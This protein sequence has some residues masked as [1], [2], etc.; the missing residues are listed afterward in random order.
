MTSAKPPKQSNESHDADKSRGEW[1]LTQE[2]FDKLLA[3]FSHDTDEAAKQYEA[4]RV[5]LIRFF[6]WRSGPLADKYADEVFNRV[7]RRIGEGQ[8]VN[9][10]VRYAYRVAYLVFL[11][12]LKEPDLVDIDQELI[13]PHTIE[14]QYEDTEHEQRQRCFDSCLDGL[15]ISNRKLILG[16]YQD[17]RKAKIERKELADQLKISLDAL[18][19]RVCRIR[20]NLEECMMNCMRQPA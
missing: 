9:N 16:Y 13:Q 5:R 11:E 10:V 3:A 8:Q 14:P 4:L 17:E 1:S 12:W 18:R 7:A 15:T 20:K 2:A 19:I 6:E